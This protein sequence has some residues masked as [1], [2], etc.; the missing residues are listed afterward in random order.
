MIKELNIRHLIWLLPLVYIIHNLEE[1]LTLQL[2]LGEHPSLINLA[3]KKQLPAWFWQNFNLVRNV[4]L[5][6]ASILPFGL[7]FF[8]NSFAK[9]RYV[10]YIFTVMA[11]IT[12]INSFQHV[13]MTVFLRVYTPGVVSAAFINIPFAIILLN[14]IQKM[15]DAV[16]PKKIKWFVIA[17]ATY[18]VIMVFIWFIALLCVRLVV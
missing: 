14:F 18:P 17:F 5:I 11:W 16:L 7:V 13:A 15:Q 12:L 1:G 3:L 6:I 10:T 9:Q 2:W 8:I 4:A